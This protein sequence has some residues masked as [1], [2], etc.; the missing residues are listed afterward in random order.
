[1]LTDS[2]RDANNDSSAAPHVRNSRRGSTRDRP[3]FGGAGRAETRHPKDAA[4][5]DHGDRAG[6]G[7]G[8]LLWHAS[9]QGEGQ[10]VVGFAA[11]KNHLS[12]TPHRGSLLATLRD[13]TAPY[14]TSK[15]S[16]KFAID[17][18]LPK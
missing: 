15:G 12:Y 14:K 10:T 11:F 18:P 5:F 6:S 2:D 9:I 16:L 3:L 1:M 4:E 8:D 17:K 13:D 7:P